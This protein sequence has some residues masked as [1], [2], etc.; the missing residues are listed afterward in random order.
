MTESLGQELPAS[1][2]ELNMRRL[3]N[4]FR[5]KDMSKELDIGLIT[6]VRE[7]KSSR[8]PG[9]WEDE[10]SEEKKDDNPSSERLAKIVKM[11]DCLK[12]VPNSFKAVPIHV[13]CITLK[14][15]MGVVWWLGTQTPSIFSRRRFWQW[16]GFYGWWNDFFGGEGVQKGHWRMLCA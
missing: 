2:R 11:L 8:L 16:D 10:S 6:R 14:E 5:Q 12:A 9:D 3:L 7:L 13:L 4:E 1:Q 15:G